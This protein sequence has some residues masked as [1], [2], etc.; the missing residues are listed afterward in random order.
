MIVF[1]IH[2][3][4]SAIGI[5]SS[6]VTVSIYIPICSSIGFPFLHTLSSIYA[7][8]TFWWR[9]FWPVWDVVLI[10]ISL[11]MSDVKHLFMCLLAICMSSLEKCLFRSKKTQ[12]WPSSPAS[13]SCSLSA[14]SGHTQFLYVSFS[15]NINWIQK[16]GRL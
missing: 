9:P 11:I 7:L 13:V 10:R 12:F 5:R 2:Q 3:H 16:D 8:Q 1:A 4:E 6:L 15:L 14:H